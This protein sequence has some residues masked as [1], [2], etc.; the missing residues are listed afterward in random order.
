MRAAH[1]FA[2]GIVCSLALLQVLQLAATTLGP[3]AS[4]AAPP[5]PLSPPPLSPPRAPAS[6]PPPT[7]AERAAAAARA[8]RDAPFAPRAAPRPLLPR[9]RSRG[10]AARRQRHLR[11]AASSARARARAAAAR[12]TRA[13]GDARG[14]CAGVRLPA[15]CATRAARDLFLRRRDPRA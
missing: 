1:L 8:R 2:A 3:R 15:G 11:A 9:S 10:R 7:A 6:P 13:A 12:R 4:P 5:P 14:A